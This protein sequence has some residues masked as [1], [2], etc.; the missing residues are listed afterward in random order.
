MCVC[1]C[2]CVCVFVCVCVIVCVCGCVCACVCVCVCDCMYITIHISNYSIC[3]LSDVMLT[4]VILRY[5]QPD[6]V[7]AITSSG[8]RVC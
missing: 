7:S 5:L 1:I 3:N 6:Y 4:Y 2:E 8:S